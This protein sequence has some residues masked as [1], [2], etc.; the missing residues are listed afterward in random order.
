MWGFAIVVALV[1]GGC[2]GDGGTSTP[3]GNPDANPQSGTWNVQES[4]TGNC[5]DQETSDNYDVDV[6]IN[7]DS[8]T[9][10]D[11]FG[12]TY[13]GT[14]NG[15]TFSSN[16]FS[17]F[18]NGGTVTVGPFAIVIESDTR[19]TASTSWTWSDGSQTCSGT[20]R[21]VITYQGP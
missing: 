9:V 20:T 15:G 21:A 4:I 2:G 3:S 11:N 18:D 14:R 12:D 1:V 7:G 16:G 6:T 19:M 13:S 10:V 17:F 8:I 5:P